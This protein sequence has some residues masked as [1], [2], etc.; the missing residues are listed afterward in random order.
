M[1]V[2]SESDPAVNRYWPNKQSWHFGSVQFNVMETPG[3][4]IPSF[5]IGLTNRTDED[6]NATT[7]ITE[8]YR[9]GVS[10]IRVSRRVAR[11]LSESVPAGLTTATKG[12]CPLGHCKR[13]ASPNPHPFRLHSL[14]A[15]LAAASGL[16]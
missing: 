13:C 6:G 5:A 8:S 1:Q 15:R 14:L 7:S 4:P 11:A 9:G 16:W 12:R 3:W 2:K 10:Q